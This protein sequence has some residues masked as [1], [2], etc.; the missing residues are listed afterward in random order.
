MHRNTFIKDKKY[1]WFTLVELI[2]VIT[3]LTILGTIGFI[4][5]QG[6]ISSARDSIRLTNVADI[7]S[8]FQLYFIKHGTLPMPD[9]PTTVSASWVITRYQWYL[10]S[11]IAH[12]I[13]LSSEGWK[14][15]LDKGYY[16]Y[17]T[18]GNQSKYQI[19]AY[20]E[21][22]SYLSFVN[23]TYAN[24]NYTNRYM[25]T[26][27]DNVWILTLADNSPVTWS[28][29]DMLTTNSGTYYKMIFPGKNTV[30]SGTWMGIY[31]E[32]ILFTKNNFKS[33]GIKS[34]NL[35]IFLENQSDFTPNKTISDVKKL[36]LNTVNVPIQITISS[37]SSSTFSID[38]TSKANA[39]TLIK[40][41]N[42]IGVSV[43]LEPY[44][45]INN[46]NA[47]ETSWAPADMTA[48]FSNW[49]GVVLNDLVNTIAIPYHTYGIYIAS[50]FVLMETTANANDWINTVSYVKGLWY[51]WKV[52]YRTN[53]WYDATWDTGVGSTTA[54]Y[55]AKLANP[56][57]AA[58]DIIAIAAYFELTATGAP[59]VPTVQ[60]VKDALLSTATWWRGQNV[61]QEVKNFYDTWHK[62]IFFGELGIPSRE[63]ALNAPWNPTVSSIE[64]QLAQ[65]NGFQGYI[66]TFSW[67]DWFKGLSIFVVADDSSPYT[68][69]NKLAEPIIQNYNP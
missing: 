53:W 15:P 25:K 65:A 52:I 69:I 50:N 30:V 14:D 61:Y 39:I 67:K 28:G 54:A 18:N 19:W 58:P 43:L 68:P 49:K 31:S 40:E 64:S 8:A 51:Q 47:S 37:T 10:S 35:N 6:H 16:V 36:G 12:T 34:G 38:A 66:E 2:V 62:P 33:L 55:S 27:G 23:V 48:F 29:I 59:L 63:N 60:N 1:R 22:A 32:S 5:T 17:T 45:V 42:N 56:L 44:P 4:S 3:I 7:N 13:G 9:S 41:L 20:L 57:F 24:A 26:L 46:W 21:D 11:T